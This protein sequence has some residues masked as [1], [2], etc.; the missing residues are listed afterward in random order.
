MAAG[1]IIID[2]LMRTGSF[3]TDSKRAEARL[4]EMEKVAK[5]AGIAIGTALVAGLTAATAAIKSSIDHMDELSKAAQRANLPTEDFSRLAYAGD[6]ADVSVETLTKSMGKLAKAQGDAQSGSKAQ[7]EAFERLGITFKNADGTLR[8]TF[9]VFTD[10]ADAFQKYKGSP[11]IVALGMQIFGRS[12]QDLIPLL[13]DGSAGIREAAAE[14]DKLGVTLSTEAG[15]AAEEFNDNITRLETAAKGLAQQVATDLLPDLL[16]LSNQLVGTAENGDRLKDSAESIA[17]GFRTLATAASLV[18]DGMKVIG[19]GVRILTST[20]IALTEAALA[21]KS[22]LMFDFKGAAEHYRNYQVAGEQRR[23][24]Q[25]D[26]AN[27]FNGSGDGQRK[28]KVAFAGQD[29]EPQ[30]LFRNP[31]G[32][33]NTPPPP[34]PSDP[35]KARAKG[36]SDEQRAAQRLQDAYESL[37]AS[38]QE[39]IA[40][41]GQ[42]SEAAKV[43]YD[44]EFG[45]L[46]NLSQAKKDELIQNAQ[47]L[48][49]L[50]LEDE[51]HRAAADAIKE[52]D[53]AEKRHSAQVKDQIADMQFELSLLSM[54]NNERARAVALRYAN[55]DAMSE[56]GKQIGDLAVKIEDARK[57]SQYY[58]QVQSSLSDSIY[59]F[60][61][62]AKSAKDALAAFADQL[63][64]I[65]AR[66]VANQLSESI[67]G[68]FKNLGSA[69]GGDSA[70]SSGGFWSSILSIFSNWGGPKAVGGDVAN[71]M[72]YL[73]G[74][75][76]PEMFVPRTAGRIIPAGATAAMFGGGMSYS[77]TYQFLLPQRID[78]RSQMQLSQAAGNAAADAIQRNGR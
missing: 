17:D 76:G 25:Q 55:V 67:G 47:K 20:F 59:D 57:A 46:K 19:D 23:D 75:Q 65:S 78:N 15:Q 6:L 1:S 49:Q 69:S 66:A 11:E 7:I 38:Q 54:T 22:A 5:Q 73:V 31:A 70:G 60:I 51:L 37:A 52:Q 72:A 27:I 32:G 8:R 26:I 41:F 50:K 61:T 35:S 40:L 42:T 12:F 44:T 29:P 48:D 43:R 16:D 2:L 3:E 71:G 4:R 13:K 24:A 30:G 18:W 64:Q 56:E 33:G 39:Q 74:E 28:V 53:E 58:D 62:G 63:F 9:D 21:A 77:P 14:A 10:F 36:L 34:P 68:W 45:D